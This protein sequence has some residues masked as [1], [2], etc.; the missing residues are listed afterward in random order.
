M[1]RHSGWPPPLFEIGESV[2]VAHTTETLGSVSL[3]GPIIRSPHGA[4]VVIEDIQTRLGHY[5]VHVHAYDVLYEG[6]LYRVSETEIVKL[7]R[8]VAMTLS[9]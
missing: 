4:V 5:E 9:S 2:S 1:D 3:S 6:V 7:R 8:A